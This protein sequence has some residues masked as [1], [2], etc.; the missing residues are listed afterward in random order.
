MA[1]AHAL[2]LSASSSGSQEHEF[3]PAASIETMGRMDAPECHAKVT[4]VLTDP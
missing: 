1:L 2:T 4:I 3:G